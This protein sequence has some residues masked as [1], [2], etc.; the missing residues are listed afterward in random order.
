MEIELERERVRE[1]ETEI[2]RERERDLPTYAGHIQIGWCR[3]S[4]NPDRTTLS[5]CCASALC[6][7]GVI[8]ELK[9]VK[10]ALLDNSL[11]K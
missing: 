3:C 2:K 10:K 8:E 1:R 9:D 6:A 4:Y 7:V 5:T 11:F